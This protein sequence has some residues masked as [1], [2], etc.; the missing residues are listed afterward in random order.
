M[1]G[2][3]KPE[4]SEGLANI[5]QG[6]CRLRQALRGATGSSVVNWFRD[7]PPAPQGRLN[8][9]E[10]NTENVVILGIFL[11]LLAPAIY[12]IIKSIGG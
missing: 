3:T 2:L 10:V 5:G 12:V 1:L 6:A 4:L 7:C 11:L 8:Q 9:G